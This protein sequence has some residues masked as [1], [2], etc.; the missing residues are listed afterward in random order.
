MVKPLDGVELKTT[1]KVSKPRNA[2][3]IIRKFDVKELK[4]KKKNTNP[5]KVALMTKQLEP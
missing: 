1:K 3:E 5:G 4:K 2:V